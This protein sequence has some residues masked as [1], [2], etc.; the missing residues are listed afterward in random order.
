MRRALF[1]SW[2]SLINQL[3]AVVDTEN[4]DSLIYLKT[5]VLRVGSIWVVGF[6][7]VRSQTVYFVRGA[8]TT[9]AGGSKS[10]AHFTSESSDLVLAQGCEVLKSEKRTET[11]IR[12]AGLSL[13]GIVN[14]HTLISDTFYSSLAFQITSWTCDRNHSDLSKMPF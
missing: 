8:K 12:H 1:G 14:S 13:S 4:K 11:H 5:E 2:A 6:A 9:A 7:T 3:T 10:Q